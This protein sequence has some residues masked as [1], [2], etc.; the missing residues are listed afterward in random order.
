MEPK[1]VSSLKSGRVSD[2]RS[3]RLHPFLRCSRRFNLPRFGNG[4]M[5]SGAFALESSS[6]AAI[7]FILILS[8]QVRKAVEDGFTTED[9]PP[10]RSRLNTARLFRPLPPGLAKFWPEYHPQEFL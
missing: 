5:F 3:L 9:A 10:L 6:S 2:F 4:V 7:C 8:Q 1:S